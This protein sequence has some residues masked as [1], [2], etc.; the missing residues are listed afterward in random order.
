MHRV[1]SVYGTFTLI[2]VPS[3]CSVD[4]S[5]Q[6]FTY[7]SFSFGLV[8]FHVVPTKADAILDRVI[9]GHFEDLPIPL[10]SPSDPIFTPIRDICNLP[11][12][13]QN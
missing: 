10:H 8:D 5:T 12:Q 2:C 3:A 6:D 11:T 7:A 13:K 4:G 9:G 1:I